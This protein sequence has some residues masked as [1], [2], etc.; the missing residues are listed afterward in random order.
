MGIIVN[1][2]HSDATFEEAEKGFHSGARGITHI[3]NAMRGFHHREPGIAGFGLLNDDIFIEVI[4]DPFH[5]HR[6]TI[7]LIMKVKNPKR[8][9]VVSDTVR[10]SGTYNGGEGV[11]NAYGDLLGGS[12]SVPESARRLIEMG[13]NEEMIMKFV[14]ENPQVFSNRKVLTKDKL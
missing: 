7:E 3:F 1:M 4:A 5:L 11:T 13:Y 8:I 14:T 6:A 9:I 10:E 2:G 12:M